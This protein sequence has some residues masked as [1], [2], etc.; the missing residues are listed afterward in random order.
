VCRNLDDGDQD[1]RRSWY[2]LTAD[3]GFV[4]EFEADMPPVVKSPGD[5]TLGSTHCPVETSDQLSHAKVV[6][7]A[8]F[9]RSQ[10]ARMAPCKAGIIAG[11]D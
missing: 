9:V 6:E 11:L 10:G 5:E 1:R 3:D 8:G 4:Q 7:L 2:F